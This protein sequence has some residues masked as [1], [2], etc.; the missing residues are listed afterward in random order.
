MKK[1]WI[2]LVLLIA[3]I[4]LLSSCTSNADTLPSPSPSTSPMMTE[5]PMATMLPTATAAPTVAAGVTTLEDA[6]RVSAAAKKEV[7]KLSEL[8]NADV[9]VAGNMAVVGVQ[10]DT[11]YQ[12]GLTDRLRQMIDQR[13]QMADKTVTVTHVTDDAKLV[14]EIQKLWQQVEKN[15]ISFAELQTRLLEIS[16]QMAG[17]MNTNMTPDTNTTNNGVT[18]PQATTGV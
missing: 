8:S 18:Q 4:G 17:G 11:Q 15:E 1:R 12:G 14:Q 9:L 2:L 10:Y 6:A 7:E 13:V 5:T 3:S 16:S